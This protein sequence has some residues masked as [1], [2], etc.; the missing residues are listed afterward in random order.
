MGGVGKAG[1]LVLISSYK[2][3]VDGDII[4]KNKRALAVVP[5]RG[6]S[7]RLPRK[8]VRKL[9]GKPLVA[10]T[11]EA[12]IESAC[13]DK[14][15]LNSDDEE[16][17]SIGGEYSEVDIEQRPAR[18]AQDTTKVLELMCEL[19]DRE[20]IKKEFDVITLLLP[21]CPFRRASHIREGYE[22]LVGDI[23]SIVSVTSYE[24]PPQLS[25]YKDEDSGLLTPVFDPCPLITGDTRSQDQ[26][27]IFRPNGGF[28]MS[29]ISKF[30]VNRNYFKGKVK[31]YAMD[32]LSSVDLD[33][34]TDF[35]YAEFLLQNKKVPH[36]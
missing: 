19:A 30:A 14:I 22:Q 33:D 12:A 26:K 23:D 3:Y 17:L 1:S 16:I 29:W 25:I 34:I 31:G 36:M 8:N 21:T 27:P 7:K 24:F 9:C 13:F 11:L 18:L 28:Y 6:G 35:E 10:Y 20:D 15:M 32:R 2:E 4:V 5:A